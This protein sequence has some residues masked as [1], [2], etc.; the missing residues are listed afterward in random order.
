MSS[1]GKCEPMRLYVEL[2]KKSFQRQ[3][4]YRSATVAGF[5][6]NLF[7]G[8]LRAAVMIAVFGASARV[9]GYSLGD[10]ITY[11]GITQALIGAT[12]LWGW[13]DMVR[14]IKSGEVASDLSKPF[15][16]YTFWLAQDIGRG[17]YQLL[18]RGVTIMIAYALI[19][20]IETPT[21]IGQWALLGLSLA[22]GLLLS[23]AWRFL[24]STT[25]FWATDALGFTRLAYFF[26]LFPSGF[27]VP[28]A[29]M[30]DWLQALCRATPFPSL[31]DTPVSIYL[32][33]AQGLDALGLLLAQ[34]VW[35]AVLIGLGRAAA[36]RGR[37]KVTIQGG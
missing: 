14:S 26:V 2:A 5:V 12:A 21:S 31:I 37:R 4:A 9:A 1:C 28:I 16:Y 3:V 8:A 7:F 27:L 36:E 32:G 25:A 30:P 18:A 22:G 23:F 34:A 17:A 10:A 35:I 19:F 33:H 13:Y 15:D 29:F 20:G 11:T 6:T 24:V